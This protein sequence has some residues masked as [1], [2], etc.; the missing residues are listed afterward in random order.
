DWDGMRV[1]ILPPPDPE[2]GIRPPFPVNSSEGK[3][4][5]S[6]LELEFVWAPNDRW[7]VTGGVGLIDT[8]YLELGDVDPTGN[9]LQPGLPFAYAPDNSASLGLQY[10]MPLS[11]GGRVLFSANYGWMDK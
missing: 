8:E 10:D 9:G 3:A 4:E 5:A 1:P 7:L 6:G 2:T 11:G